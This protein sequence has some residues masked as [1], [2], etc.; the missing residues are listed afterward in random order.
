MIVKMTINLRK[1]MFCALFIKYD[2][3]VASQIDCFSVEKEVFRRLCL[4][5]VSLNC[6]IC[7][8]FGYFLERIWCDL[9]AINGEF[10]FA[11]E[12]FFVLTLI[13]FWL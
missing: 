13:L 4:F 11:V 9:V 5:V 10:Q 2:L 1:T 7:F 12:R 3:C 6:L 8:G